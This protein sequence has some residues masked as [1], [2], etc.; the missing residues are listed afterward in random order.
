MYYKLPN[1][2]LADAQLYKFN[3]LNVFVPFYFGKC[4]DVIISITIELLF[5]HRG[6]S[7]NRKTMEHFQD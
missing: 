6:S 4:F 2:V 1:N 7:A 5:F 3:I